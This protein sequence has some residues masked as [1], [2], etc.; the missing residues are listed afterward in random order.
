MRASFTSHFSELRKRLVVV[1]IFFMLAFAAFYGIKDDLLEVL[2]LPVLQALPAGH[3][4]VY[5]G[6]GELFFTYIKVC[7]LAAFAVTLPV[8][9]WQLWRFALP[10]LY[11]HEKRV[12]RPYLI[13]IPALFY[14]GCV[15]AFTLIVPLALKFFLG[16]VEEGVYPLPSVKE[17]LSFLLNMLLAF[18]LSF[19]LPV[20]LV[21]LMQTGLLKVETLVQNRRIA[22]VLV[23]IAAAILTP[24]DP[25]S[26]TML[27]VPMILLYE[28][29]VLVG[30]K[31]NKSKKN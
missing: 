23:F 12:L 8:L 31:L 20:I 29:S 13:A 30:K 1:V 15:F 27:A 9:L 17:Y 28:A 2:T 3:G 14:F 16:F 19:E 11:Q 25:L 22:F 21:L 7:A 18:G 10:G 6:V 24:P 5:T 4:L 26:Q